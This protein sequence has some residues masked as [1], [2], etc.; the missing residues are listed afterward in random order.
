VPGTVQEEEEALVTPGERDRGES[1]CLATV[2]WSRGRI[3]RGN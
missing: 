1:L 3:K 2:Y